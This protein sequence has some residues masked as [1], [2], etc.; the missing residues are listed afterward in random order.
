MGALLALLQRMGAPL[1]LLQLMVVLLEDS[2]KPFLEAQAPQPQ[3]LG[4]TT[5]LCVCLVLTGILPPACA[6]QELSPPSPLVLVPQVQSGTELVVQHRVG[7]VFARLVTT[8][9]D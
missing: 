5:T 8:G 2:F 6:S 7:S 3:P 9:M 4:T 1:V